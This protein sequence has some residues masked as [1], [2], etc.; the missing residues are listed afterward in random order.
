VAGVVGGADELLAPDELAGWDGKPC[1]DDAPAAG[2][3]SRP[4]PDTVVL[5]AAATATVVSANARRRTELTRMP[6]PP[7]EHVPAA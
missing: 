3:C 7:N 1:V 6:L 2:V 4:L 5:H